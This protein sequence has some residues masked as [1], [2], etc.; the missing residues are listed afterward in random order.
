MFEHCHITYNPRLSEMDGRALHVIHDHSP[1][2]GRD[3]AMTTRARTRIRKLLVANRG[4]IAIR[5][6]RAATELGLRT[7]TVFSREDRFALHR[8]K[9]DESY[10]IGAGEGPVQ[11]YLGIDD[12][13]RVARE[14][15]VDAILPGYGFLSEK[16]EFVEA[17]EAA[18]II[19]VGPPPEVMRRLGNKVSARNLAVEAGIPVMPATGPLPSDPS[20]TRAMAE[21]V[22]Y[23]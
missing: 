18:G 9:S 13:V 17:C 8:F 19:F 4:E 5:V 15:G 6:C 21:E 3:E 2:V 16:P 10:Q 12:I 14:A 20:V 23:P 11:A 7:V 1:G 22:G